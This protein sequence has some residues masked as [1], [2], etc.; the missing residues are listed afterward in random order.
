VQ[1]DLYLLKNDG[2][3]VSE[4]EVN[5][6]YHIKIDGYYHNED[7]GGQQNTQISKF[8]LGSGSI[9]LVASGS[10]SASATRSTTRGIGET[11]RWQC[12]T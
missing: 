3:V 7:D 2:Y 12:S 5:G 8:H 11:P 9:N 6:Y 1:N 4:S 10:D